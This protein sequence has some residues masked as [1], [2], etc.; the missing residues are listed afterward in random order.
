MPI[1]VYCFLTTSDWHRYESVQADI[2]DHFYAVLPE[3]GLAVY[4]RPSGR[5]LEAKGFIVEKEKRGI[6]A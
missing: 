3:F 4:Q 6:Q 2:I 5:D 1:E